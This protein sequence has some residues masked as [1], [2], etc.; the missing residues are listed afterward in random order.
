MHDARVLAP[1]LVSAEAVPARSDDD[2]VHQARAGEAEAREELARRFREPAYV[3]ALQLL[4]NRDDAFDVAQESMLRVFAGLGQFTSGRPLR[5]WVLAIVRNQAHDLW[6]RKRV[7]RAESIDSAEDGLAIELA[8]TAPDP[9]QAASRRHLRRRVWRAMSA[10]SVDH[11]E[12]IVLR[13]FHGLSYAEIAQLLSIKSGTVMSRLH[14]A[15]AQLR[16][17]LTRETHHA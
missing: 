8:D 7:R 14:G 5:P 9:E 15:R 17:L 6:R 1:P 11:R 4:G 2:L 16:S 13:D 12:V 3:L 10:L